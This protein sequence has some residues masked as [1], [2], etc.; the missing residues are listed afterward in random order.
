[1]HIYETGVEF[2]L[3][4]PAPS[5]GTTVVFT[6]SLL[7]GKFPDVNAFIPTDLPYFVSFDTPDLLRAVRAANLFSVDDASR[8][9]INLSPDGILNIASRSASGSHDEDVPTDHYVAPNNEDGVSICLNGQYLMDG[10]RSIGSQKCSLLLTAPNKPALLQP[11]TDEK[12]DY[13]ILPMAAPKVHAPS[14]AAPKKEQ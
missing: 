14:M 11:L 2:S 6:T 5:Y 10:L 7:A 3:Y 12:L 9:F 13:M 1:M 4:K 8:V